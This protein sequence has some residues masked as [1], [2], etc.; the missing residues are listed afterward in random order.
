LLL[1]YRAQW[2]NVHNGSVWN[3]SETG[4][5]ANHFV[6]AF[7]TKVNVPVRGAMSLGL[8]AAVFVRESHYEIVEVEDFT[9]RVPQARLYLSWATA[10]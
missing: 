1:G 10:R 5:N 2:I 8:D 4:S 9:Q 3:P 6:H 7:V